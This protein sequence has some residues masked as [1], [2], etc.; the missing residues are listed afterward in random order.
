MDLIFEGAEKK[1]PQDRSQHLRPE[2]PHGKK[3][4]PAH[5]PYQAGNNGTAQH[6]IPSRQHDHGGS[7]RR[8]GYGRVRQRT[9]DRRHGFTVHVALAHGIRMHGFVHYP[10]DRVRA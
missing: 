3:C 5:Q 9:G 10:V 7:V 2:Q 8:A 4:D 6:E 1:Q